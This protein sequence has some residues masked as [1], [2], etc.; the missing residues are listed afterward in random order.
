MLN[1]KLWLWSGLLLCALV[2]CSEDG[3]S[4]LESG[5][6]AQGV[7]NPPNDTGVA[8]AD[9]RSETT[10]TQV[11]SHLSSDVVLATYSEFSAAVVELDAATAAYAASLNGEN[12]DAA[13][14]AWRTAMAVWQKAEMMQVGPAGVMGEVVGGLDLR[15]EIYSWPLSNACRVDQELLEETHTD[16][17]KLAKEAVNTRG[18]DA[19]EYALFSD[20]TGNACKS[21]ANINLTGAWAALSDDVVAERRAAYA[22]ACATLLVDRAKELVELWSTDGSG[23]AAQLSQPGSASSSFASESEALNALSD[24][25]FY[26]D[27][28]TKDMKLAGP[29]GLSGCETDTC[30]DLLESRYAYES[31]AHIRN[32]LLGVQQLLHGAGEEG[33]GFVDLLLLVGAQE[34]AEDMNAK[35]DAAIAAVDAIPGELSVAIESDADAV[36][37]A[38]TSL[39]AFTT[40]LKTQFLAVLDLQIPQRAASDND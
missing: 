10:R 12:R 38:H 8:P 7:Q 6:D 30:P 16:T 1:P 28:V 11:L 35:L 17:A 5:E 26:V 14:A 40:L 18:L 39:S 19:I 24:A 23:F 36:I 21:T 22:A 2:A 34:L 3:T 31:K 25:L 13:R 4:T 32:N 15:D 37:A 27:K 29:V 33:G 20:S 9:T